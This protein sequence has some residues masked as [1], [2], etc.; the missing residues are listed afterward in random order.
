MPRGR[1]GSSPKNPHG[2]EA[3][4]RRPPGPQKRC[5]IYAR[6][7]PEQERDDAISRTDQIETCKS[8]AA[9]RGWLVVGVYWDL[10][11]GV[12]KDRAAYQLL[13]ADGYEGHYDVII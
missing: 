7:S 10:R 2:V 4:L 3:I 9:V 13:L 12:R 8:Y 11:T 5:A 6:I 1:P